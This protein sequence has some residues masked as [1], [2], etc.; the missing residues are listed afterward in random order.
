MK[1]SG[2]RADAA[3]NAGDGYESAANLAKTLGHIDAALNKTFNE[4]TLA[5]M[6]LW[7]GNVQKMATA[8]TKYLSRFGG[9]Q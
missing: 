9:G 8:S 3:K 2:F 7:A 1:S 6:K 5:S 4:E